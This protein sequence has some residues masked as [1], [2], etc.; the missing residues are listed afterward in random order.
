MVNYINFTY[1]LVGSVLVKFKNMGSFHSPMDTERA[2][3]N[4]GFTR[5]E[6]KVYLSLLK[7]G[8]ATSYTIVKEA[9]VSSGK[10]YETLDKLI[11]RGLVSY[12]IIRGKKYFEAAD[13]ER[14]IDYMKKRELEV[15]EELESIMKVMPELKLKKNIAEEKTKA[16]VYEGI[17]GIKTVYELM[18][19]E[20]KSG[21][22]ILIL[23][24]PKEA[25]EK[26]DVYFDNFNK[27]RIEKGI[28]LKIILNHGHPRERKLKS[29][30]KTRVRVFPK[31]VITPSWFN[32]SKEYVAIFNLA[33]KPI[34]FL[35]KNENIARS[36]LQY[37][38]MMWDIAK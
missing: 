33:E 16:E 26:L 32:I 25:G 28:I 11:G 22:S 35:I 12:V 9:G 30:K 13:P 31:E 7:L 29:L 15:H 36:Y 23:G 3:Q 4:A 38:N 8:K 1:H 34:V 5:N 21:E 37:F 2:L 18:L 17:S 27:R 6:V 14:L 10:I 20:A 24:A 19:R